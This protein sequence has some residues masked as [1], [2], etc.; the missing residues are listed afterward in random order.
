MARSSSEGACAIVSILRPPVSTGP[1][2][3]GDAL[4]ARLAVRRAAVA[5][6]SEREYSGTS[7]DDIAI[8]AGIS[9]RTFFR[10]F[11]GKQE[12]LSS[13]HGV[14]FTE[15][16]DHLSRHESDRTLARAA[17][18]LELVLDAFAAVPADS[19]ERYRLTRSHP[20]LKSEELRWVPRYQ[21][22]LSTF[23]SEPDVGVSMGAELQAASL[24]AAHNKALR[25]WLR[26][27]SID[28]PLAAFRE[29]RTMIV[30]HDSR[31]GQRKR[32]ALVET[33]LSLDDIR[34]RLDL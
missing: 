30:D 32:I 9:R 28:S 8:A 6:F 7:V 26:D 15:V 27:S 14:F 5:L 13:D 2:N 18:A 29:A 1:G 20:I 11:A 17:K 19:R 16:L 33:E 4:S 22:A 10:L 34:A 23:L 25:E 24:V 3:G 12:I 31:R 21:S